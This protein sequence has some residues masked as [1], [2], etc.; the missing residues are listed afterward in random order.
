MRIL[1]AG[2]GALG[3]IFG[4]FLRGAGFEVTL[5][6]RAAHVEVIARDGLTV[7]GI[8]GTHVFSGFHTATD[9]ASL[10]GCFDAVVLTVKS[11]DTRVMAEAVAPRL[12]PDSLV[13]SLQNGLGNVE[14][15][16]AVVGPERTLGARVIF[17]A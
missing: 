17:G 1:I 3:S 11:Y 5:L 6:G 10:R 13:L 7:D 8:W 9:A 14:T 2:A 16:E 12:A 15:I 4:G